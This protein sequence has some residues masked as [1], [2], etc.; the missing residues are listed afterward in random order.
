VAPQLLPIPNC[1]TKAAVGY[2]YSPDNMW[3]LQLAGDVVAVGMSDKFQA[4]V[5]FPKL[6]TLP[7]VGDSVT[8]DTAFGSV[9]GSK[10]NCDLI[11]PVT[12]SVL[13]MNY[14]LITL[15]NEGAGLEPIVDSPYLGGWMIVVQLSNPAELK[16][17]L[18]PQQYVVL[19]TNLE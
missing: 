10:L 15:S 4:L 5:A 18:S 11:S 3:V 19:V 7:K 6:I 16:T 2:L 17:L 8:K 1:I 13:D 14:S 12:G 9:E